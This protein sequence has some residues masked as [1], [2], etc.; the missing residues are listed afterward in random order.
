MDTAPA[1][2]SFH[3][4][5]EALR[6][7]R[8]NIGATTILTRPISVLVKRCKRQYPALAC[9]YRNS[10]T[11]VSVSRACR[12]RALLR[13]LVR[14]DCSHAGEGRGGCRA[15]AYR[16]KVCV[17]QPQGVDDERDV[18]RKRELSCASLKTTVV[19][20]TFSRALLTYTASPTSLTTKAEHRETEKDIAD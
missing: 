9:S 12:A 6:V 11:L 20:H 14:H 5:K 18:T 19:G 1:P 2:G 8:R 7:R 10:S 16:G 15:L 17:R 3:L 13:H 4:G